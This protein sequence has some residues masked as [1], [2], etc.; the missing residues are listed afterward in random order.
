MTIRKKLLS[1][2]RARL[3]LAMKSEK[4]CATQYDDKAEKLVEQYGHYASTCSLSC[5][6]DRPVTL[7]LSTKERLPRRTPHR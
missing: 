7:K 6:R 2:K 5:V 3:L 4:W 1:H